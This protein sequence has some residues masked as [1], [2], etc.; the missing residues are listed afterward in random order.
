MKTAINYLLNIHSMDPVDK[1]ELFFPAVTK[2]L[3]LLCNID[4]TYCITFIST[5]HGLT[6]YDKHPSHKQFRNYAKNNNSIKI[7]HGE[8]S[9]RNESK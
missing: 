5:D 1:H 7:V 3:N 6:L 4:F 8:H 9:P 2:Q